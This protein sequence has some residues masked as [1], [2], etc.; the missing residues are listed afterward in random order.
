MATYDGP[1]LF[2]DL[3]LDNC[4]Y[5]GLSIEQRFL[6]SRYSDEPPHEPGGALAAA[7]FH[8]LIYYEFTRNPRQLHAR[9]S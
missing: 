6:F 2:A 4:E 1:Q 3:G 8:P 9:G 7:R 5:S